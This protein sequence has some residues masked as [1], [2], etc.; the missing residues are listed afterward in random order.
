MLAATL[1]AIL[2]MLLQG[3]VPIAWT[4]TPSSPPYVPP[5]IPHGS[6][7]EFTVTLSGF[8]DPAIADGA[9]VRLWYQTNGMDSAWFSTPATLASNTVTAT[10][11]PEQDTGADRVSL[12][13]GA[14]S[15]VF[16]AAILRLTHA[17]GFAPVDL[18]LPTRVL[19]FADVELRNISALTNG[20]SFAS[21]ID[22]TPASNYVDQVSAKYR[23]QTNLAYE[24]SQVA[25]GFPTAD[26]GGYFLVNDTQL[27]Y[28]STW[29]VWL[30]GDQSTSPYMIMPESPGYYGFNTRAGAADL[31]GLS[32]SNGYTETVTVDGVDYVISGLVGTNIT[33]RIAT[34]LDRPDIP[35][36]S[37]NGKTG[38]VV[39]AAS[40][41]GAA[42][43]TAFT[44]IS[45]DVETLKVESTL[46]YRLYSGSNVVAEVTN[47][48]SQVHAPTL[49]LMQLDG[50]NGYITVWTETNGL[51]RIARASTNYTD[52]AVS[53]AE[54]RVADTYAPKAWSRTTSGLGAE[55]PSNTTWVS[56]EKTVL[57]G[58]LDFQ[59]T[60]TESG[61][62]WILT[63]N[64]ITQVYTNQASNLS[65][66]SYDGTEIFAVEKSDSYLVGVAA[67][68]IS[69]SGN[70][71][72][73]TVP[74]VADAHP[75]LRYSPTLSPAAW[76]KEE[77]GFTSNI[78]VA[79]SGSSGAWTCAVTTT[80]TQGFFAFEF[81]Q[82]GGIKITNKG[83]MDVNA[84]IL[85]TDGVHKCRPVY[86]NGSIT[87][88]VVQ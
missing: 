37:V 60:L 54:L 10:F 57:A 14:P 2:A 24:V 74:V 38:T 61:Q 48:N 4:A 45:K 7:I 25:G 36:Q 66:S 65:L 78:T 39:L 27:T 5:P 30:H 3:A 33:T 83:A 88:E 68:S 1:A 76:E 86:S 23:L 59:K 52:Q 42:P 40:D 32:E 77:D 75:Y 31:Y 26:N 9:D 43:L 69:V 12:F 44:T 35:V 62:I 34:L 28:D 55:A 84:G 22:L 82:E 11:G 21:D 50:T 73:M 56:T 8:S 79:W 63:Y 70:V 71:V 72:T 41:V 53:N 49:R 46:V 19:D 16:A 13:F 58:G 81:F 51:F 6:A 17:P 80:A 47:Y 15:N 67:D 85:C 18:P 64:G 20:W 29:G 87:W